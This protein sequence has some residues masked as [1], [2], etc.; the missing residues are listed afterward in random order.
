M[1]EMTPEKAAKNL[2]KLIDYAGDT[3]D[4]ALECDLRH[5]VNTAASLCRKV[6][7][8]KLREVVHGE[9][10]NFYNDFSTA[11]CSKCGEVYEVSPEETPK[12]ECFDAFR[13]CY[14]YCPAC[15]SLMDGKD[16][17]PS[18]RE[19]TPENAGKAHRDADGEA[20]GEL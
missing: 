1:A 20:G 3:L 17:A 12:S 5:T 7:E 10:L 14:K 8:G 4:D 13:Q 19:N 6:A 18:A 16:A 2:E 9:W 15:G 11:E